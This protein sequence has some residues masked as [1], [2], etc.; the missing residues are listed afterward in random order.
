L[1]VRHLRLH[2]MLKTLA[3]GEMF[4]QEG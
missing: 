3:S 1:E 4:W 2:G